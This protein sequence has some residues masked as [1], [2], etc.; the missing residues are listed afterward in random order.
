MST[1]MSW[2][3]L[4]TITCVGVAFWVITAIGFVWLVRPNRDAVPLDLPLSRSRGVE[5]PSGENV[6]TGRVEIAG[7]PDAMAQ[8]LAESLGRTGLSGLLTR[9][10]ERTADRVVFEVTRQPAMSAMMGG[11]G[12]SGCGIRQPIRG[13]VVFSAFGS[14]RTRADFALEAGAGRGLVVGGMVFLIA[15]LVTLATLFLCLRFIVIGSPNPALRAQSVQMLQCVHL[16]WPPWLCGIL[17]R[18]GQ[19]SLRNALEV[20]VG[21]LPYL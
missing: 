21:N 4:L 9:V 17:Y 11:G 20:L 8:K 15:G 19:D 18:R 13:E 14:G 2:T 3:I 16:I 5:G 10:L 6:R 12:R 1:E 7:R